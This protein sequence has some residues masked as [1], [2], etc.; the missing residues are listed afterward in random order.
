MCLHIHA[1]RESF[2]PELW[3]SCDSS[4]S[5]SCFLFVQENLAGSATWKDSSASAPSC[6]QNP[7]ISRKNKAK[8]APAPT[9]PGTEQDPRLTLAPVFCSCERSLRDR[10]AQ[11]LQCLV[12]P[13]WPRLQRHPREI[14][15]SVSPYAT[16]PHSPKDTH[17]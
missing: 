5:C 9:F 12:R 7:S 15:W 1:H 2:S 8:P 17:A 3:T 14:A 11:C 13:Q 16:R 6:A 4:S 10:A